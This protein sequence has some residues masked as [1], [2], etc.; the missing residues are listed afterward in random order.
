M[1]DPPDIQ[2]I[3]DAAAQGHIS[4]DTLENAAEAHDR[5]TQSTTRLWLAK[6][7]VGTWVAV[8]VLIAAYLLVIGLWRGEDIT[9]S[10]FELLKIGVIPVVVFVLG[11]YYGVASSKS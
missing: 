4:K 11:Y 1:A 2:G 10:L 3:L 7:I 8:V 6:L 5:V 9:S